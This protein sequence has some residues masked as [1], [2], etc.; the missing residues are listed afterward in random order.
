MISL[1]TRVLVEILAGSQEEILSK[2]LAD[3]LGRILILILAADLE[4]FLMEFL[5]VV[6]RK[7]VIPKLKKAAILRLN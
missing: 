3:F 5:A 7:V 2:V 6:F 1:V 4:I